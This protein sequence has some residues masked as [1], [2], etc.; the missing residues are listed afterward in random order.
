MTVRALFHLNSFETSMQADYRE[1]YSASAKQVEVRTLKFSAVT[2]G[3]EEN[4]QF[5]ASTP[6]G[7]LILSTVNPEVWAEFELNGDYYLDF[8]RVPKAPPL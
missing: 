1:G 5:F 8:T 6:S 7:T 2:T 4:K 3:S